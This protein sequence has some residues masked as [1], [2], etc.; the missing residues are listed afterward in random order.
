ML[1]RA[2]RPVEKEISLIFIVGKTLRGVSS[3]DVGKLKAKLIAKGHKS[4]PARHSRN[5]V[6]NATASSQSM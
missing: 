1:G 4:Q 3:D 5:R 6:Q 2:L